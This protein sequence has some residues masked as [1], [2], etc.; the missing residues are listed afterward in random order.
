MVGGGGVKE[1][2]GQKYLK[3]YSWFINE[4]HLLLFSMHS[5][6]K[7]TLSITKVFFWK[8]TND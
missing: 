1:K 4:A 5:E 2:L 6:F 7:D 8:L 3:P